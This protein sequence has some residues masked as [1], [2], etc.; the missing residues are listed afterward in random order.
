MFMMLKVHQTNKN[1]KGTNK[2]MYESKLFWAYYKQ[3][4]HMN[5]KYNNKPLFE[6][7]INSLGNGSS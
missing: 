6:E 4:N 3:A 2:E 7:K 1:F 5:T